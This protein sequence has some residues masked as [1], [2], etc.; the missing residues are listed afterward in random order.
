M[1][2]KT[3]DVTALKGIIRKPVRPVTIRE[4]N[5]DAQ[6]ASHWN[7]RVMQFTGGEES[8]RAIHEVHYRDGVPW[9]YTEKPAIVHW[10]LDMG[11]DDST[12]LAILERMREAISKPVL[13]VADFDREDA[14]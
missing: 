4:M 9:G 12:A 5:L 14:D 6:P 13:R 3:K 7:Y 11:D 1:S 10:D 2:I 8:W